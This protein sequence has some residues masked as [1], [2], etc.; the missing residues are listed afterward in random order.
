MAETVRIPLQCR[1][2]E[3]DLWG[4]EIPWSKEWL[5]TPV[6]LP[7]EFHGQRNLMGHSLWGLKQSETTEQLTLYSVKMLYLIISP[8][9]SFKSI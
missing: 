1:S 5:F 2:P 3:F 4:G 8:R 7:G 9:P 6:S